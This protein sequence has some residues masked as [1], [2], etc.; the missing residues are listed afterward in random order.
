M[1]HASRGYEEILLRRFALIIRA[2]LLVRL[3]ELQIL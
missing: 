3:R 1:S 2:G